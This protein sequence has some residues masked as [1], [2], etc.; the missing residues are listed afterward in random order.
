MAHTITV[1]GAS[2]RYGYI[3]F[4][5]GKQVEVYADSTLEAQEAAA[6]FFKARKTYD[7]DV[8]LAE[9]DG[10][11]VTHDP[12][13]LDFADR[14]AHS[15]RK[16]A[17]NL[18]EA[19]PSRDSAP[20]APHIYERDRKGKMTCVFCGTLQQKRASDQHQAGDLDDACWEGYEA[21]GL[22]PGKGGQMVPNCVPVKSASM[23]RSARLMSRQEAILKKYLASGGNAMFFDELPPDVQAALQR[24]KDHETLWSDVDRWLSDNNNPHLRRGLFASAASD[25]ELA[26]AY[27]DAW[28]PKA[29]KTFKNMVEEEI[30]KAKPYRSG[31]MSPSALRMFWEED[32]AP[33]VRTLVY[34]SKNWVSPAAWLEMMKE[35]CPRYNGF[36]ATRVARFLL[37]PEAH[38]V[39]VQGA[40]E[41]SPALYVEGPP[42]A[43]EWLVANKDRMYADDAD[44]QKD[45]TLRLWW[46]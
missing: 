30:R 33:N 36:T 44:I 22:K 5:R 27:A 29:Y 19:C 45:G 41:Y 43:L 10:R 16:A 7:V 9:K 12:S 21:V 13:V 28:G 32:V 6:K 17:R 35:I 34:R 4:Y 18:D 24:V 14:L 26:K 1:P 8:V 11:P 42:E 23:G 37:A 15:A 3:A 40:R 38:G 46:D 39:T 25:P 2:G 31:P 20:G